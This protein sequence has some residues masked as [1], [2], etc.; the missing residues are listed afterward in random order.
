ML[1]EEQ[2]NVTSQP[3]GDD[4]NQYIQAL[5]ELKAKSVD[6][7]EYDKLKAENKKLLDSIVNGQEIELPK[8]ESKPSIDE[9]RTKLF[10]GESDLSNLEFVSNALE[11]RS[12]HMAKG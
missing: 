5:N 8:Q 7:E 11:L 3:T 1:E 2:T 12:K 6:R 4:N 10:S 9:L